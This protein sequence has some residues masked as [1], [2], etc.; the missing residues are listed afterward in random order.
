M[1]KLEYPQDMGPRLYQVRSSVEEEKID[2]F[3]KEDKSDA[4]AHGPSMEEA[5]DFRL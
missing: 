2:H 3:H 1:C 5:L 4:A